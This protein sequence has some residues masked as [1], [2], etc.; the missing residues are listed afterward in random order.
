M[1]L[2]I[3]ASVI[4][5]TLGVRLG[6]R[7]APQIS[8]QEP[9]LGLIFGIMVGGCL[10]VMEWAAVRW[11]GVLHAR[12]PIWWLPASIIA[13]IIGEAIAFASDFS[14]ATVP[15]VALGIALTTGVALMRLIH[16]R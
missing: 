12:S 3:I 8:D 7:Y 10:G 14:Q 2:W 5:F 4:G 13:W 11:L 6:A 1:W 16:P 15:L 9:W